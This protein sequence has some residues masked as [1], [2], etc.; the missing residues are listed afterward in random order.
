MKK[1]EKRQKNGRKK[2][3]KKRKRGPNGAPPETGPKIVFY[4]RTVK[5]NRNEI[6][7]QKKI[8]F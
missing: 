4:I 1:Q 5:R 7:P 2:S 6:E 8:R 3:R